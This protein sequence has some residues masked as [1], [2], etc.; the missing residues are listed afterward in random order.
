MY[1]NE[2]I[3][4]VKSSSIPVSRQKDRSGMQ[5]ID[6]RRGLSPSRTIPS[7]WHRPV[8]YSSAQTQWP[9]QLIMTRPS[10]GIYIKMFPASGNVFSELSHGQRGIVIFEVNVIQ[11]ILYKVIGQTGIFSF[12][13]KFY[14]TNLSMVQMFLR[15][16]L[17]ISF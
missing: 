2:L 9:G 3:L 14:Y 6:L 8:Q 17:E 1:S 12:T 10:G 16:S 13:F 15:H 7:S 5:D 4:R 11:L